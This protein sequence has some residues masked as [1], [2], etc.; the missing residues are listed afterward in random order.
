MVLRLDFYEDK[1]L[2]EIITR[3]SKILEIE[4]HADGAAEDTCAK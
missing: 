3:S 1:E 4:M 2:L